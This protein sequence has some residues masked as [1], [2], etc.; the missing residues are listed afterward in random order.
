MTV[1]LEYFYFIKLLKVEKNIYI[2]ILFYLLGGSST[3]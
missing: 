3:A 1:K 2:Y